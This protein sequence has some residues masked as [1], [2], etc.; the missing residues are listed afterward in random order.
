MNLTTEVTTQLPASLFKLYPSVKW[1]NYTENNNRQHQQK[2]ST[3]AGLFNRI[4]E[5]YFYM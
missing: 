3:S 2:K 1:Y 5:I 4:Q